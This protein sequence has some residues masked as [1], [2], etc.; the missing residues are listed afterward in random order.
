MSTTAG[1][2][3]V[4]LGFDALEALSEPSDLL[5]WR[6]RLSALLDDLV[7][8]GD[9]D[10]EPHAQPVREAF[11]RLAD[12]AREAGFT[13]RLDLGAVRGLLDVPFKRCQ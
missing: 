3:C 10:A 13:E 11:A 7:V 6:D 8:G 5:T 12:L 2:F 1:H 4:E 9:R